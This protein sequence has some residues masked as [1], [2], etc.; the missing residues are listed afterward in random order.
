MA[1]FPHDFAPFFTLP[2]LIFLVISTWVLS[3][4]GSYLARPFATQRTYLVH[5]LALP[6]VGHILHGHWLCPRCLGSEQHLGT[7]PG[8]PG[9]ETCQFCLHLSWPDRDT[10]DGY[11]R[12]RRLMKDWDTR[13]WCQRVP[14]WAL[15]PQAEH[16][17]T[18]PDRR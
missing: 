9:I 14:A 7:Q 10:P 1:S 2:S 15:P 6:L 4:V 18:A 8:G 16:V 11:V 3:K 5:A 13:H 12:F 17:V